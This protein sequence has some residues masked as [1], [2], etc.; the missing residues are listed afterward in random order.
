MESN[1][2][3]ERRD[4]QR[5]I[6]NY[7]RDNNKFL[8]RD[9]KIHY[10]A[11]LAMDKEL[12]M[13]FLWATQKEKLEFLQT[14][15]SYKNDFEGQ[16]ISNINRYIY[17]Y[18][19]I[20]ALTNGVE[21]DG[22]KLDLMYT[23]PAMSYNADLNEKYENNIVSVMEEVNHKEDERIDLVIFLNGIAIFAIELKCN[24]SGQSYKDAI[25]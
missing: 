22:Q 4:Y 17:D 5:L 7:L 10:D 23:K 6:L 15:S 3:K 21:M 25:D 19:L 1:R 24:L 16:I 9:S 11:N 13:K 18:S 12:L 14:K 2:I 8:E 20:D